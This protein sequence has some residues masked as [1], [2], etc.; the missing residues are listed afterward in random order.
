[1]IQQY[2]EI[3]TPEIAL[4][5]DLINGIY[6][7]RQVS[8]NAL[9]AYVSGAASMSSKAR[10]IERFYSKHYVD[11]NFLVNAIKSMFG[12]GKFTLSLDRTNW[13]FGKS[14]I[15]AFAAFAS[16]GSECSLVDLKMLNNKGGNSK[17]EDRIELVMS[18]VKNYGMENIGTI[19]GDRE[20]FSVEF[21]RWLSDHDLSYAIRLRENLA[22]IQPYLKFATSKGRT[23]RNV[24]ITV[25]TD[26][27]LVCDLSIKILKDEY[28]I[29]ASRKV[30]NPLKTYRQRW[31]IERFFKMLKTGGFNLESTK[32]THPRR[33]ETLFLMC[34]I[35]YLVCIKIGIFRHHK[36]ERMR[37]KKKSLCY[38]YSYFRWGLDWIKECLLNKANTLISLLSQIFPALQT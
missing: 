2:F 34:S 14:D 12:F 28:L 4:A 5:V 8:S 13:Q 38:E 31:G 22:F 21:A 35:A 20:F 17:S 18:I 1:M 19:L 6:E 16:R 36:I 7:S 30:E 9:S 11:K 3:S 29:I 24:V 23:F 10:R 32:I 26:G 15:N 33:L 27:E 37:W 25:D